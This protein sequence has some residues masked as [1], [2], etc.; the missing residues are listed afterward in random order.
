MS[1]KSVLVWIVASGLPVAALAQT[2]PNPV[3]IPGDPLE[4]VTG[5]VSP[6]E[7]TGRADALR[8]L[9]HA[10]NQYD[11]HKAGRAYDL[12]VAFT[13]SSSGETDHDGAWEMEDVFDPRQGLRWTA[14]ASDGYAITRISQKGMLYGE[15]TASY[16][17]LRLHEAR[18]AL[19]DPMAS[20]ESLNR[21]SVRTSTVIYHGAPITCIL[22]SG[23]P[24]AGQQQDDGLPAATSGRRWDETEECIDPQSELLA[25]HSPVPGRYYAYDYSSG[26]QFADRALPRKVVVTEGGRTVSTITV[27]SVTELESAD[28]S[29]FL[30]TAEMKA[31][32]RPIGLGGAR[33]ISRNFG[34]APAAAGAQTVCV[35]GVVT[36]TGQLM[37]AHSLQPSEPNSVAAVAAAEKMSF[38]RPPAPGQPPQQ[39]FVF[40]IGKFGIAQ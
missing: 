29:L 10:R 35:F 40:I 3:Q 16:V 7:G 19:F 39:Y 36:S 38:A 4:M 33:K 23:P 14:K 22:L 21:G 6:V 9:E 26:S 27:E 32:G 2:I 24:G 31:N 28:A 30:P 25:T 1:Y 18:A 12:K 11:L 15:E 8:L 17:P 34:P 37:E 20:P 13:V 5:Q